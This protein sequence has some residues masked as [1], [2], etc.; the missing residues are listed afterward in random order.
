MRFLVSK[1]PPVRRRPAGFTIVEV[2]MAAT[3]L[4]VGFIGMMQTVLAGAEMMATARRQTLAAQIL[5]HEIEKLRL[6]S[7]SEIA[8][9]PT[10]QPVP[11]QLTIDSQ[12]ADAITAAGLRANTSNWEASDTL[13]LTRTFTSPDPAT[14]LREANFTVTW[15]MR[16]TGGTAVR[17]F[18]RKLSAYFG[19]HGLNLTYQR[20]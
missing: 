17:T 10:G 18:V 15:T 12:F 8:A 11:N 1:L 2:M 5:N 6:L 9:L 7:W 14:D 13:T 4:L 20:S 19:K 3:I 16:P